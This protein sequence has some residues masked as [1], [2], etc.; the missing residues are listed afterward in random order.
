MNEE[1]KKK[2]S[3]EEA[4]TNI[5]ELREKGNIISENFL[6]LEEKEWDSTECFI[7]ENVFNIKNLYYRHHWFNF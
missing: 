6:I 5:L 1:S 2:L 4:I 3:I 7:C